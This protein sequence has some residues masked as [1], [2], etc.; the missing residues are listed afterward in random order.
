MKFLAPETDIMGERIYILYRYKMMRQLGKDERQKDVK[1][2]VSME[3][4]I[5]LH[6]DF[7]WCKH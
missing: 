2:Y 5:V 6:D 4:L 7:N 3:K 1:V